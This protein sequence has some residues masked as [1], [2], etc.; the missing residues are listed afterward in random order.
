MYKTTIWMRSPQAFKW[1][2]NI[3]SWVVQLS[4]CQIEYH[5]WNKNSK[6][7]LKPFKLSGEARLFPLEWTHNLATRNRWYYSD[8]T[9]LY[10]EQYSVFTSEKLLKI[11]ILWKI[12][13]HL[14]FR[15]ILHLCICVLKY[16]IIVF[17]ILLNISYLVSRLYSMTVGI[18]ETGNI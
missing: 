6:I 1:I 13:K 5:I 3:V 9:E 8:I 18:M 17:N 16:T 4:F 14:D 15:Q 12:D 2:L 11:N 7:L 10:L